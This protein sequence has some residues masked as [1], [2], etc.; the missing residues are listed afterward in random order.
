[1]AEPKEQEKVV[2]LNQKEV[3]RSEAEGVKGGMSAEP[4]PKI[5]LKPANPRIIIPCI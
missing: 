1:M 5:T 2:D 4:T 3:S